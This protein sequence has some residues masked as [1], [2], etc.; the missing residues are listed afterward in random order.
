[1]GEEN[2]DVETTT[3]PEESQ[4]V[5]ASIL[6]CHKIFALAN[7]SA[8]VDVAALG[9]EVKRLVLANGKYCAKTYVESIDFLVGK[10]PTSRL[11]RHHG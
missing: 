6:L 1:M 10:P 11:P 3:L 8:G 2:M 4:E 9:E 7:P 5:D